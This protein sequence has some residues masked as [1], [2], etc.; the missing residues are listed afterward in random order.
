MFLFTIGMPGEAPKVLEGCMLC[1]S[2]LTTE[3]NLVVHVYVLHLETGVGESD[4]T[5]SPIPLNVV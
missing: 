4:P 2:G 1:T 3:T 5:D